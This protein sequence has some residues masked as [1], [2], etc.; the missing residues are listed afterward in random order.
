MLLSTIIIFLLLFLI[1]I[2]I[3]FNFDTIWFARNYLAKA[4]HPYNQLLGDRATEMHQ[5]LYKLLLRNIVSELPNTLVL[6]ASLIWVVF[7]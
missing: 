4:H 7:I 2:V 3:F 6:I 1:T 5:L